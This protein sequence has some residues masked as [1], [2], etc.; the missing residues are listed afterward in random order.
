L[1]KNTAEE[2][3]EVVF[4]EDILQHWINERKVESTTR[5]MT[6]PALYLP[7]VLDQRTEG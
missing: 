6:L 2:P 3:E 7:T 1:V 5:K 4:P